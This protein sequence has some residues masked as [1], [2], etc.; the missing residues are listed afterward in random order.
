MCDQ[1]ACG[2]HD[3]GVAGLAE[4]HTRNN[5]P[6]EGKIGLRRHDSLVRRLLRNCDTHVRLGFL[7]KIDRAKVSLMRPRPSEARFARAIDSRPHTVHAA[8]RDLEPLAPIPIQPTHFRY[9][10]YLAQQFQEIEITFL[11][12]IVVALARKDCPAD[13]LFDRLNVSGELRGGPESLFPLQLKDGKGS[14]GHRADRP[15][16]SSDRTADPL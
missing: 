14:P 12:P 7:T 11:Q 16:H 1:L 8:T 4:P 2:I 15:I 3:V 5:V 6:H 9:R 10:W 13:L